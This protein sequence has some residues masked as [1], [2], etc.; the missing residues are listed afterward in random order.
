VVW[1]RYNRERRRSAT[2][3]RYTNRDGKDEIPNFVVP[4]SFEPAYGE[5][6]GGTK[7][8]GGVDIARLQLFSVVWD[9]TAR[10]AGIAAWVLCSEALH[11][12]V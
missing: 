4:D 6:V 11:A 9:S 12:H 10:A 1:F 3:C 8:K 5:F 2:F 7:L